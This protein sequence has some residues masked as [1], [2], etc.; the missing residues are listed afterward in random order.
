MTKPPMISMEF[1]A[2]AIQAAVRSGVEQQTILRVAGL[3]V[4]DIAER[5]KQIPVRQFVKLL[6]STATLSQN[7]CF[8]LHFGLTY[9]L[10]DL[11]VLGYILLNS[12]TVGS[13]LDTFIQYFDVCQQATEVALTLEGNIALL[14]YQISDAS[15]QTRRQDAEAAM[16]FALS[17]IRTLTRQHWYPKAVWLEH[18][19]P[20][21]TSEHH[22]I[23][24]A[25]L[26]F[27]QPVNALVMEREL[28]EQKIPLADQSLLPMLECHLQTLLRAREA[29]SELVASVSQTIARSLSQGCPKLGEVASGLGMSDRTLQRYLRD[30]NVTFKQ[31][32]D[33]TRHQLSL[34][35]LKDPKMS[36]T[37]V[38]LLLGYSELSA[39]NHAFRRWTGL[40]PREYRQQMN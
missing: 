34:N 32:V 25:P 6:E 39:F 15:I 14:S 12:A 20:A 10:F 31:L 24:G 18:E 5:N 3:T 29:D 21:D 19:S 37:E 17:T 7:H 40:T 9:H 16:A 35:Y 1:V 26:F 22:R 38:A 27:N 4:E 13:A 2:G 8:G 11:G 28:L 36:L 23:L 30:R 33:E